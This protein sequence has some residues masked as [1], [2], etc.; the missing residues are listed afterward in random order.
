MNQDLFIKVLEKEM[1]PAL[2]CTDPAGPAYAAAYARK[3]A[4]GELLS[5]SAE[6]SANLI[7][8]AAAVCIPK[9]CGK[10]GIALAVAVGAFGGSAEKG[11]E[12][13]SNVTE[14]DVSKAED[15]IRR[16]C[17]HIKQSKNNKKLYIKIVVKTEQDEVVVT[18]E[19]SYT[20]I[21][22]VLVNQICIF[23]DFSESQLIGTDLSY[24]FLSLQN[25]L[26]FASKVPIDK[27]KI[28]ERAIELNM[29]IAEEGVRKKYGVSVGKSIQEYVSQGKMGEDF[30][31]TAVMWTAAATDAR[32]AGCELPVISNT[33]SGNQGLVST[34]PVI[35]IAKK[36]NSSYEKMIR[37][38]T[39]S[40][41]V[42]VYIK[43]KLGMLSAVCGAIIA[44]AGASCG[45]VYLLGGNREPMLTAL[46]ST[47]GGLAGMLCDGA[48]AGCAIKVAACTNIGIM[49][50]LM[51]MDDNGIKG[52]DGI[53]GFTE[54]QTIANFIKVSAEGMQKMDHTVLGIILQKERRAV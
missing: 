3:H 15:F 21:T 43:D 8:N 16:G 42:T 35:S 36:M 6:L 10:C 23:I 7:K 34:V 24:D 39:I 26:D 38:V 48:K 17:V 9:T 54:E 28:I 51:A 31:N 50:A 49:A 20:R 37:A 13:F 41:L 19:D 53:V 18:I 1:V 47:L 45:V 5:I 27:L 40:S 11:L 25:I 52:T 33:G 2:G 29:K 30:I 14:G 12:V 32:M 44:A 46:Q 22:S 4:S